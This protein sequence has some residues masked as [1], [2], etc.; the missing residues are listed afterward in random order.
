MAEFQIGFMGGKLGA[1]KP[2]VTLFAQC[3][4]EKMNGREIIQI[5]IQSGTDRPYYL[6][7]KGIRPEGVYVRYGAASVPATVTAIRKMIRETD[8]DSYE[9]LRSV[10]QNLTFTSANSEFTKR[11][12][13]FVASQ[14]ATLKMVSSDKIY[15][16]LALLLS[17]QCV[18]TIKP[19]SRS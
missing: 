19:R 15:T 7:G 12:L 13:Q 5:D 11:K 16:N 9:K 18:H 8:G 17:E 10:E 14:M 4:I 3:H 6:V 1:I 2:D